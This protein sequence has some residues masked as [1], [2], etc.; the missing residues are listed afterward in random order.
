MTALVVVALAANAC[1]GVERDRIVARDLAP[2][3]AAFAALEP[4]T[5]LGYA[6]V[7][8]AKRIFHAAELARLAARNGVAP[9][10]LKDVC[11]ERTTEPLAA[12]SIRR[13]VEAA[14]ARP[15]AAIEIVDWSR[16]PA[17]HGAI[18]FPRG[19][20]AAPSGA[21]PA[22]WKGYVKYGDRHRF[23]IWAR[24]RI[25]APVE[26]VVAET[27]L[28][29]GRMIQAGQ[30]RLERIEAWPFTARAAASVDRVVGRAPRRSIPKGGPVFENLLD[31]PREVNAGDTVTVE[32]SSGGAR[33]ALEGRAQA[34]GRRGDII[35]VRNPANGRT[36]RATVQ[37]P[38]KV[39]LAVAE[40]GNPRPTGEK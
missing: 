36:F 30:V 33:L 31:T 32:V 23:G 28:A 19:G 16:Y 29:A 6:P 40:P 17:P 34:A 2:A 18:E 21:A 22:L 37:G 38:G 12:A 13:A 7:P 8:G 39:A 11:V 24:V 26:R 27:D 25:S 10:E 4:D 14:V 9:G 3:V 5:D 1:V 35:A 20:L 15:E